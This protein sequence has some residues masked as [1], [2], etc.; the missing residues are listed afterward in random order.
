[1]DYLVTGTEV[2]QPNLANVRLFRRFQA[3]EHLGQD[4]QQTVMRIIDA[5]IAQR[6][7]ASAMTPMD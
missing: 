2:E 1:M 6:R 4:D 5:L 7:V 3:L